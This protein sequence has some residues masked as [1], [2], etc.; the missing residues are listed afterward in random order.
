M[1]FRQLRNQLPDLSDT[2]S[3]LAAVLSAFVFLLFVV[4]S[5]LA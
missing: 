4:R 5:S 3:V 2:A 1:Q